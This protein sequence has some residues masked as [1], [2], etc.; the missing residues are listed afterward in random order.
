MYNLAT[1]DIQY[2]PGVGPQ[3]AA[4]LAKELGISS[5]HDL[6]YNF[7]YKY[8]DRSRLYYV[9]EIDGNMPYVQL[10]GKILRYETTGTGRKMRLVAHF[11]DG[12]G[13]IDLVWFNGAKF[14]PM[15]LS[16][17]GGICCIWQAYDVWRPYQCCTSRYR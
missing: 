7:P 16:C 3:R 8:V 11:S 12:T 4:L 5:M 17:R 2:L 6:L 9:H 13:V 14:I 1:R 10:K 15:N